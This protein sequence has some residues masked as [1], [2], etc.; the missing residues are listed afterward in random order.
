MDI[1]SSHPN[2]QYLPSDAKYSKMQHNAREQSGILQL[3]HTERCNQILSACCSVAGLPDENK[4][5]Q[6]MCQ[7]H[8]DADSH[9]TDN[10]GETEESPRSAHI[11]QH[12]GRQ[13]A[14][15]ARREKKCAGVEA[16]LKNWGTHHNAQTVDSERRVGFGACGAQFKKWQRAVGEATTV[17]AAK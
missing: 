2:Q 17:R 3:S 6:K 4:L 5:G 12:R 7:K 10:L 9:I 14:A 16:S 11:A 15:Y 1:G 13:S 8:T